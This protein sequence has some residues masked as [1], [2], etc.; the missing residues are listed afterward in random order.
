[1]RQDTSSSQL[2]NII[3]VL[4]RELLGNLVSAPISH[5]TLRQEST[6]TYP[7][8]FSNCSRAASVIFSF[9]ERS[10]A[11]SILPPPRRCSRASRPVPLAYVFP[12]GVEGRYPY[13][14]DPPAGSVAPPES[15]W[16]VWIGF[17]RAWMRDQRVCPFFPLQMCFGILEVLR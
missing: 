5:C 4:I 8:A 12:R 13:R 2:H 3:T 6:Y 17:R 7:V 10:W 11:G 9:V 16:R 14:G 15:G 1:M